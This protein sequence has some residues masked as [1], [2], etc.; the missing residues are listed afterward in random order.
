MNA[1]YHC[2][3]PQQGLDEIF[4]NVNQK[5][6]HHPDPTHVD[7]DP[8]NPDNMFVLKDFFDA[9]E[10]LS[11]LKFGLSSDSSK[12]HRSQM[13]MK[14]RLTTHSCPQEA[15]E[16][17]LIEYVETHTA[18]ADIRNAE[19]VSDELEIKYLKDLKAN[20][21]MQNEDL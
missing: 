11:V 8:F 17:M 6:K 12:V 4:K 9:L 16:T 5:H 20:R 7:H 3:V 13:R 2:Y 10:K 19:L 1:C 15:R 18:K 21:N 14:A